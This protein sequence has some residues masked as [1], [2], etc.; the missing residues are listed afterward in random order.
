MRYSVSVNR[1]VRHMTALESVRAIARYK[2]HGGYTW[3][4]IAADG[5]LICTPCIR[6]NYRLVYRATKTRDRSDWEC[7]GVA[8]SD[9]AETTEQCA[10]CGRVIWTVEP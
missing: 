2:Y 1:E 4:A 6:E 9:S 3:A 8:G 7:I 5:Q 10:H